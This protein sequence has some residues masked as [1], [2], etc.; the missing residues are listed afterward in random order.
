M[1]VFVS[2]MSKAKLALA[3]PWRENALFEE[4]NDFDKPN[5]QSK[6]CFNFAMVRKR[7]FQRKE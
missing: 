4:K 2:Q 6:A 7:T 5:E 3:L 1:N